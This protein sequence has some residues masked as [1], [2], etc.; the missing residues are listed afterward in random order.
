MPTFRDRV[1]DLFLSKEKKQY[2]EAAELIVDY[3]KRGPVNFPPEL[4]AQKL[5]ELD[6]RY[7][8]LL[9][10]QIQYGQTQGYEA[11]EEERINMLYDSRQ[12]YDNDVVCEAI[13]DI[14]TDFGFGLT[15]EI[16]PR[17]NDAKEF[18]NDFWD[19]PEN[20]YLLSQRAINDLSTRVLRD[21]DFLFIFFTDTLEGTTTIR[22][23][24]SEFIK[25]GKS[26][27]GVIT[28]PD[29]ASVPVLYRRETNVAG[30]AKIT[31]Y[32]DWRATDEMVAEV[33]TPEDGEI[34]GD[35]GT[36]IRALHVAHR[37]RGSR[38]WPLLTTGIPW[39]R[40]YRDFLEDRVAVARAVS[41]F[42]DKVI[43]DGGQKATDAIAAKLASTLST[44]SDDES[45][46]RPVAGSTW[47]ENKAA[48][49]ERMPLTT[50]ASDAE[51]DGVALLAQ[52]GLAGR[53]YAHYLG[54]GANVYRLATA[55]SMERPL[56]RAFNRYQLFWS[57]V[58][59][60]VAKHVLMM[61]EMFAP[62]FAIDEEYDVDVN[63]NSVIDV[64]FDD[65]S[66]ATTALTDLFDR[67][68]I[69]EP[70]A[71][72]IG[73]QLMRVSMQTI[74][75]DDTEEIFELE[76]EV[77]EEPEPTD[78]TNQPPDAS[79]QPPGAVQPPVPPGEE[80]P[81][82]ELSRIL[83]DFSKKVDKMREKV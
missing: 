11:S 18:W 81:P 45:N 37:Q 58:W 26:K 67:G 7:R 75:I 55:T 32:Q 41:M 44:G 31:Y 35:A 6:P 53:V 19:A 77:P 80:I 2:R 22:R 66:K 10:R 47:V 76:E 71:A 28:L 48:T 24:D 8:D 29:D 54:R 25:G 59:K 63:M 13:I 73:E 61:G 43:A 9:M 82:S 68:L 42:V 62:D 20:S 49:R 17:N 39:A 74:G 60:D 5:T 72:E 46:P 4:F 57:S 27:N 38:G 69:V 70:V 64:S 65:I 50:G 79:T 40:A 14:W 1:G 34:A 56:L 21:G 16:T 3:V 23:V 52:A 83:K 78:T 15:V 51:T 33:G 36:F 30:E 12:M